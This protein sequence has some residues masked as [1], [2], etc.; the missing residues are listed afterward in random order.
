MKYFKAKNTTIGIVIKDI[1]VETTIILATLSTT[2]F[3]EYIEPTR[4]VKT[5]LGIEH[6]INRAPAAKPC[7][8]K[9]FI[10]TIPTIG[11]KITLP[12]EEINAFLKE[13]TL[14]RVNAIPRDIRI[15]KIVAYIKRKVVFSIN[16]GSLTLKY[17]KIT[18][19]IIA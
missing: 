11:P 18:E 12:I 19:I 8:S 9:N 13:K 6:C 2:F 1:T 16:T 10:K 4:Y 15:K 3:G 7:R 5:A 14:K 17:N